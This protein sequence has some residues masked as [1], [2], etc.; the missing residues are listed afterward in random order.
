MA[1]FPSKSGSVGSFG[2]SPPPVL[3]QNLW[4]LAEWSF[5]GADVLRATQPS[6]SK[7]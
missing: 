3:K 2:S 6:A 7:H 4:G 5:Y 1:I